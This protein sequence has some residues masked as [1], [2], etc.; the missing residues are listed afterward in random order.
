MPSSRNVTSPNWIVLPSFTVAVAAQPGLAESTIQTKSVKKIEKSRF[1]DRMRSRWD[2]SRA[3][4][5]EHDS[6]MLNHVRR[7]SSC[8]SMISVQ[9]LRVCREGKPVPT[10]PDH[11]LPYPDVSAMPA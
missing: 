5:L 11:A 6:T 2:A 8:L 9:T 4:L 3:D 10:F 1:L 7:P